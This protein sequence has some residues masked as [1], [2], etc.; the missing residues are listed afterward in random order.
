M[1]QN[2]TLVLGVLELYR[3]A[4]W[5][6]LRVEWE[7]ISRSWKAAKEAEQRGEDRGHGGEDHDMLDIKVAAA[8]GGLDDALLVAAEG[9]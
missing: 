3:R 4:Q 5:A 6:L 8:N 7:Q 9:A 2:T 1:A